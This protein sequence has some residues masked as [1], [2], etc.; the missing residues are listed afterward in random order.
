MAK[1][2]T[3]SHLKWCQRESFV[4]R[5]CRHYYYYNCKARKVISTDKKLMK[6]EN[7]RFRRKEKK[8]EI[9]LLGGKLNSSRHTKHRHTQLLKWKTQSR[10][11]WKN[12]T[13]LSKFETEAKSRTH[14][15]ATYA[16]THCAQWAD[17]AV[18]PEIYS[19]SRL[20]SHSNK[21]NDFHSEI[22]N[23]GRIL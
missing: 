7:L 13:S 19:Q 6:S 4:A 22:W 21:W 15:D 1:H 5:I 11:W 2:L 9:T 12:L 16:N 17:S 10:S 14:I 8:E 18:M 3:Q 20:R 23:N